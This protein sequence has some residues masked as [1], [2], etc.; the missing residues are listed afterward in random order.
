MKALGYL[1]S[2]CFALLAGTGPVQ[3]ATDAPWAAYRQ[4]FIAAEGRVVDTGNQGISHSE[5]QGFGMLLAVHFQDRATF[6]RLWQ[7]TQ[8]RLQVRG[9][10]L[11]AWQW[12][13]EAGVVDPNDATDG[14]VL[15]A[16]AL[17]R[18]ARQWQEPSWQAESQAIRT[19]ILAKLTR[20]LDGGLV[21]LP[22]EIGFETAD[23]LVVNPSYWVF[24]AFHDFGRDDQRPE[25]GHLR[26]A[27]HAL[28]RKARFGRWDLPPDWLQVQGTFGPAPGFAARFGYDAVRV[29]LYLQWAGDTPADLLAPFQRYWASYGPASVPPAW[30][31]LID[32][33]PAEYGAPL[34]M[35][36]VARQTLAFPGID[37]PALAVDPDGQDYYSTSLHLLCRIMQA[38]RQA[39]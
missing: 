10:R 35:R 9:D 25:W 22:G 6:E 13:P 32:G 8:A 23:I 12:T 24:P 26:D 33:R 20:S 21:L 7:W 36:T 31:D 27:G 1:L 3:M 37:A 14:D 11:F 5:G 34:G 15:I 38:D 39:P 30:L 29:P 28:L 17:L 18:A 19:D 16:W 4:R 2:T